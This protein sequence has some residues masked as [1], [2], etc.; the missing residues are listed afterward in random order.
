MGLRRSPGAGAT[1][2]AAAGR[3]TRAP[4]AADEAA[5][6][7]G[8]AGCTRPATWPRLSE[9][10]GDQCRSPPWTGVGQR[11]AGAPRALPLPT[12]SPR[13]A[14]PPNARGRRCGPSCRRAAAIRAAHHPGPGVGQRLAG[15]PRALPL[16][17]QSPRA[18]PPPAAQGRRCGPGCRN[19]AAISAAH[20]PGPGVGQ[21][22]AGG[23]TGPA[24]ARTISPGSAAPSCTAAG[25]G[26]TT[27]GPTAA[28][29]ASGPWS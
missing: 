7:G 22:P 16:P 25:P 9:R 18:A 3:T 1:L 5:R 29:A 27:P 11:L 8:G 28:A 13:A 2:G 14:P 21:R 12:Q 6:G 10:R 24:T 26:P 4:D 19:A 23:A 20:H 17:A 15:G